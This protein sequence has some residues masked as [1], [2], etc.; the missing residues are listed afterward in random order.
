MSLGRRPRVNSSYILHEVT[1]T[2]TSGL[3]SPQS[4]FCCTLCLPSSFSA[5]RS[6]NSDNARAFARRMCERGSHRDRERF[7]RPC[8]LPGHRG[9][10]PSAS[11]RPLRRVIAASSGA[12]NGGER[13]PALGQGWW[14]RRRCRRP[15]SR[16]CSSRRPSWT[17]SSRVTLQRGLAHECAGRP[18]QTPAASARAGTHPGCMR[19]LSEA[20]RGNFAMP[21]RRPRHSATR[22]WRNATEVALEHSWRNWNPPCRNLWPPGNL[23]P[24]RP[25]GGARPR[26]DSRAPC[27]RAD[28]DGR[29]AG[30]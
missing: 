29:R 11:L 12:R 23:P 15:R 17:I 8:G 25:A 20:R 10:P 14:R 9:G 13:A 1:P 2:H 18:K 7:G 21:P 3:E 28:A 19:A 27:P 22:G 26:A 4:L 6:F 30:A 5:P 16:T 24:R